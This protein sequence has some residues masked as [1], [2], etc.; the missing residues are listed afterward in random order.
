MEEEFSVVP[1]GVKC[2]CNLCDF[3]EMIYTGLNNWKSNKSFEHKCNQCENVKYL[4]EKYPTIR[5]K[6]LEDKTL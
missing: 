4:N 2:K 6:I 1:I 5:Y 3:G